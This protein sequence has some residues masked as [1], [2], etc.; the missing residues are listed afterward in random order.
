MNPLLKHLPLRER[1]GNFS[2]FMT[3]M[4]LT[5][6]AWECGRGWRQ[7]I[8]LL[9]RMGHGAGAFRSSPAGCQLTGR[10][11]WEREQ[12]GTKKFMNNP[13]SGNKKLYF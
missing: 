8:P 3:A 9:F 5:R 7:A 1:L 11:A 6:F 13:G 10:E 12:T 4:T 2:A